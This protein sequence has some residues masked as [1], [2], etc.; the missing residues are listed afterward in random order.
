MM[1]VCFS[2]TFIY[3]FKKFSL[4]FVF[5]FLFYKKLSLVFGLTCFSEH[6]LQTPSSI[7]KVPIIKFNTSPRLS[8]F[9]LTWQLVFCFEVSLCNLLT[10]PHKIINCH[11]HFCCSFFL[12][13][14]LSLTSLSWWRHPVHTETK[15]SPWLVL[16]LW[17]QA[18][19]IAAWFHFFFCSLKWSKLTCLKRC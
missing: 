13:H 2:P 16:Y 3:L 12:L 10:F 15:Q 8:Y 7:K 18:V 17:C 11:K 4:I 1:P 9:S 14:F 5:N 19:F 6:P